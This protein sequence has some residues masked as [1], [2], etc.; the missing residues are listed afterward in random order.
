MEISATFDIDVTARVRRE[1]VLAPDGNLFFNKR[2]KGARMEDFG[3]VVRKFSSFGVGHFVQNSSVFDQAR[4][5]GH[6]AVDV[7]PD[8]EFLGV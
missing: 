2:G 8:P 6:D 3:A 7:G 1:A 5:S 4:I